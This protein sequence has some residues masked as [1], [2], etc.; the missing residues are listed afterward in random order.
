MNEWWCGIAVTALFT[1]HTARV[2]STK[3]IYIELG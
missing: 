2:T 1:V 3:L